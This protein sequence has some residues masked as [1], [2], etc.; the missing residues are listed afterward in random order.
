MT[1]LPPLLEPWRPWL[2][3]FAD[4]LAAPLGE[5]MLR[6][7]PQIGPLRSA[8]AR[9]DKLPEGIGSIVQRGPYERMLISEWAIADAEP[10]EF[11][12]RAANHELL[13]TGPEPAARQRSRRCIALF[14]AGPAQLGEARLLHL[15]LFILLA[16]RAQEA[17]ASFEWGVLQKPGTLH[18][19]QDADG[20]RRL[21]MARTLFGPD[22]APGWPDYAERSMD[23]L[24]I[25]GGYALQAPAGTRGQV[26]IRRS[27][28][29]DQL[30]VQLNLQGS[31]RA[32]SLELP[33]P[34]LATRLLR[35]PFEPL[36]SLAEK[37]QSTGRASLQQPPRFAE[38][39]Q[40]VAIAQVDGGVV[41][42][43]IPESFKRAPGAPRHY[44]KLPW[45][46]EIGAGVF[47]KSLARIA[48][49]DD[50]L[51][52]VGFPSP[53]F[54]S[55]GN[56]RCDV[57]EVS[58]FRAPATMARW[59]QVFFMRLTKPN[60]SR[61][62][63]DGHALALDLGGN[64]GWWSARQ[65]H[66]EGI[67]EA[68]AVSF[69]ILAKSVIGAAQ[70]G[71][72]LL[73]ACRRESTTEIF[74]W[75]PANGSTSLDI[76]PHTGTRLHFGQSPDWYPNRQHALIGLQRSETEW[77]VGDGADWVTVDVEPRATVLGIAACRK[78]ALWGLVIRSADKKSIDLRG[79]AR[80]LLIASQELIAQASV[81]PGSAAIAWISAPS[82]RVSVQ[83]IN[84]D[85][86]YLQVTTEEA[87]H[88]Q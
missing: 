42:Y 63:D 47:G 25:I 30:D 55:N 22:Q 70:F 69:R 5:L 58:E 4:D 68:S 27:M 64:L 50:Q 28:L 17:G 74:S 18:A 76:L 86:P 75:T 39:G 6:L 45:G 54:N 71:S 16:R 52:L 13:F 60:Q 80:R 66:S 8:P 48:V 31:V 53:A 57:P 61:K 29:S 7:D 79:R 82:L 9:A 34:A 35:Q 49:G 88:A 26:A 44:A 3:L 37:R 20:L 2:S 11:I 83:G 10:D 19:E 43:H 24:W 46:R 85:K 33:P 15:A 72:T 87:D 81:D 65:T 32:L 12:R 84:E 14:D 59:L 56:G 62:T 38:H 23:D 41:V 51:M 67:K 21:L 77:L 78:H 40:R 1:R 73:Y 36:A